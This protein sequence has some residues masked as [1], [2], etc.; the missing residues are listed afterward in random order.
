MSSMRR[1]HTKLHHVYTKRLSAL[2]CKWICFQMSD[3]LADVHASNGY[4]T[5]NSAAWLDA[6][7]IRSVWLM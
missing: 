7:A 6:Y 1:Q 2:V 3:D 4:Y 5:E